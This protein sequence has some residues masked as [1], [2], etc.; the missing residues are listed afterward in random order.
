MTIDEKVIFFT[1]VKFEK[2][3]NI[4]KNSKTIWKMLLW[5]LPI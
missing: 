2:E 5:N 3:I 1:E 4:I